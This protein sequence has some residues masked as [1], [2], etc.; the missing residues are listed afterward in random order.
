MIAGLKSDEATELVS[1]FLPECFADDE[2]VVASEMGAGAGSVALVLVFAGISKAIADYGDT[3]GP[4]DSGG[5]TESTD[6]EGSGDND[7]DDGGSGS[8]DGGSD[9]DDSNSD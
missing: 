9:S 1:W 8:D 4:T 3:W 5:K 6:D 7:S 2:E